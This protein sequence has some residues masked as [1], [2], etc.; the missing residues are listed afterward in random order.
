MSAKRPSNKAGRAWGLQDA[1]HFMSGQGNLGPVFLY[2]MGDRFLAEEFYV[3][4][5]RHFKA[6]KSLNRPGGARHLCCVWSIG[7]RQKI[8][9]NL[10]AMVEARRAAASKNKGKLMARA[11]AGT[12]ARLFEI[13]SH[14]FVIFVE[15]VG[16]CFGKMPGFLAKMVKMVV[17]SVT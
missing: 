16:V 2:G 3:D 13:F 11:R 8:N 10:A 4:Y 17:F 14:F 1:R 5:A 7:F 12:S 9:L 6:P 15:N